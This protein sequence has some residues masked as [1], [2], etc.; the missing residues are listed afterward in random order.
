MKATPTVPHQKFTRTWWPLQGQF[1]TPLPVR[2]P[3]HRLD[4]SGG[5]T[6]SDPWWGMDVHP[7]IHGALRSIAE[8][9][10]WFLAVLG[11][12]WLFAQFWS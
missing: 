4:L 5:R 6:E 3:R 1:M 9:L 2:R 10:L 7:E 8:L 11:M 12:I